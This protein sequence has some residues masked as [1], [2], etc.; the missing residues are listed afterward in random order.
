VS[1]EV[2]TKHDWAGS[3][4]SRR[5]KK[6]TLEPEHRFIWELC[7][8]YKKLPDDPFFEEMDPVVKRWAYENWVGDQKDK[9]ELAKGHAYLLASFDH[10]EAVKQLLG[11][12]N[13]H[14]ST[15]EEFE[16]SSRMV[17]EMSPIDLGLQQPAKKQDQGPPRKR[18]RR[19]IR[20][21]N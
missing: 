5:P 7:K 11:E 18:K 1:R 6:I 19:I 15:D 4:G 13:V 8:I 20:N 12:G 14:V 10:P 3:G 21:T 17:R 16:E 2:W 9:A